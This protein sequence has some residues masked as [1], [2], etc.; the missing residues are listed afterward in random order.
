MKE[1]EISK[2][3]EKVTQQKAKTE[4]LLNVLIAETLARHSN[5]PSVDYVEKA[6]GLKDSEGKTE[7]ELV[8]TAL[9]NLKLERVKTIIHIKQQVQMITAKLQMFFPE[10]TKKI[11]VDSE[12]KN[13]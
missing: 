11:I 12:V 10:E 9:F 4:N 5:L 2:E 6:L 8:A 7:E 3:K 1:S 13:G